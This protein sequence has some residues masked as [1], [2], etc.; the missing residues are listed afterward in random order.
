MTKASATNW[1]WV[2]DISS[3]PTWATPTSQ[4]V[5]VGSPSKASGPIAERVGF[6]IG[7]LHEY[8]NYNFDSLSAAIGGPPIDESFN[9]S[10]TRL[11]PTLSYA[12]DE[13]VR[14]FGGP[15]FEFSLEDGAD[16]GEAVR[17]GGIGGVVYPVSRELVFTGGLIVIEGL[18]DDTEFLPVLGVEWQVQDDLS[19]SVSSNGAG[20]EGRLIKNLTEEVDVSGFV[21]FSGRDYRLD[22]DRNGALQDGVLRDDSVILGGEVAWRPTEQTLLALEAGVAFQTIELE[23]QSRNRVF[24]EDDGTAPF[25]GVSFRIEF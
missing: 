19:L 3:S 2:A 14:L 11:T 9:V 17:V 24:D 16:S 20:V 10:R 6:Q 5:A 1:A 25:L 7:L 23:T 8:S 21:G 22:E 13:R 15:I 12:L 4:S 18:G